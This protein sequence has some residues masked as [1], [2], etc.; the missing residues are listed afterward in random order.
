MA[1]SI[2]NTTGVEGQS[3]PSICLAVTAGLDGQSAAS[4]IVAISS[5][6]LT[7]ATAPLMSHAGS[8]AVSVA[9][10][11]GPC[12][13]IMTVVN[14]SGTAMGHPKCIETADKTIKAKVIDG[15]A[16]VGKFNI[17]LN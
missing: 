9:T 2:L 14:V 3:V 17:D 16:I 13:P 8:G 11:A 5:A 12:R 7:S 4:A 15:K 6:T 1:S 10:S